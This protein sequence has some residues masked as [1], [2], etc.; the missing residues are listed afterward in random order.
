MEF[1]AGDI[2]LAALTNYLFIVKQI[3]DSLIHVLWLIE[4][5]S[6]LNHTRYPAFLFKAGNHINLGPLSDLEKIIYG[7]DQS[8]QIAATKKTE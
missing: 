3:D 8:P 2:G 7:V 6:S 5:H 1:K 4:P